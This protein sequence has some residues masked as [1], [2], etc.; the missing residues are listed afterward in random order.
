MFIK[1]IFNY[2][3][4]Y[5]GGKRNK[6]K[7]NN[8]TLKL[9]NTSFKYNKYN[10]NL[11]METKFQQSIIPE[12]QEY[13]KPFSEEIKYYEKI[14]NNL[15][16][17]LSS[18]EK[19]H[20]FITYIKFMNSTNYNKDY[21]S[22]LINMKYIKECNIDTDNTSYKNDLSFGGVCYS[23]VYK[24]PKLDEKIHNIVEYYEENDKAFATY[25]KSIHC[26]MWIIKK[27]YDIE[28]DIGFNECDLDQLKNLL[29]DDLKRELREHIKNKYTIYPE[30]SNEELNTMGYVIKYNDTYKE[31]Y[32]KVWFT[33]D[34]SLM[35]LSRILYYIDKYN[36]D[37]FTTLNKLAGDY[38]WAMHKVKPVKPG[39]QSTSIMVIANSNYEYEY[40]IDRTPELQNM[41][42]EIYS[43]KSG[44]DVYEFNKSKNMLMNLFKRTVEQQL[45]WGA[46]IY[47]S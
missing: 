46:Q 5:I 20:K 27:Y 4:N 40:D 1:N 15:N 35:D 12:I 37:V 8:K 22:K 24:V 26:L 18:P 10:N 6:Y 41:I 44:L 36:L 14:I 39:I 47:Y 25:I 45:T 16:N 11:K 21:I 38:R 13:T 28:Y 30:D 42:D 19:K 23:F 29:T 3:K 43:I 17:Y 31:L 33:S 2:S 7:N 32:E 9:N 34:C